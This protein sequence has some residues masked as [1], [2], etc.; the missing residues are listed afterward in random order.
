MNNEQIDIISQHEKE[1]SD[2]SDMKPVT[3]QIKRDIKIRQNKLKEE[4]SFS[5]YLN[6]LLTICETILEKYKPYQ[7]KPDSAF[8]DNDL[9]IE[10]FKKLKE[11]I[12]ISTEGNKEEIDK[13]YQDY[14]EIKEEKVRDSFFLEGG[15]KDANNEFDDIKNQAMGFNDIV[16]RHENEVEQFNKEKKILQDEL[17]ALNDTI[18]LKSKELKTSLANYTEEDFS[19]YFNLNKD[20]LKLLLF[21]EKKTIVKDN[22]YELTKDN[23]LE[24]VLIDH[25]R[26][27]TNMYAHLKRKYLLQ[28]FVHLY[29][30]DNLDVKNMNERTKK[31]YNELIK[32]INNLS[33]KINTYKKEINT[34]NIEVNEKQE[35]GNNINY[36]GS[37]YVDKL[38]EKIQMLESNIEALEN[39]KNREQIEYENK[40]CKLRYLHM[41]FFK[42]VL[43]NIFRTFY[44]IQMLH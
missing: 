35:K 33:Q 3:I 8:V 21:K 36:E 18:N 1:I 2:L 25:S 15:S 19:E 22:Q 24:N 34:L 44:S 14:L 5:D 13:F 43:L 23:I 29:S 17:K 30:E 20:L 12:L 7:T 32:E 4:K 40:K 38:N 37:P 9:E 31:A 27:K 42:C 39:E 10:F 28:Y 26:K 16:I 41:L 11:M 6:K